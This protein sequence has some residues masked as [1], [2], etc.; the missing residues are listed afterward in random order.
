MR[1]YQ[2]VG[3]NRCGNSVFGDNPIP[4][5]GA[6]CA[7]TY[8]SAGSLAGTQWVVAGGSRR[9]DLREDGDDKNCTTVLAEPMW[10]DG[11]T[12]WIISHKKGAD[13]EAAGTAGKDKDADVE[14][15]YKQHADK[16]VPLWDE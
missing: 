14:K 7:Y 2:A 10:S 15:Y 5:N 1:A 9:R 4:A 11:A 3:G 12:A 8:P 16:I 13:M 6:N